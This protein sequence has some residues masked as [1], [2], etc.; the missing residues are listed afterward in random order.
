MADGATIDFK[1]CNLLFG[2]YLLNRG[3][4]KGDWLSVVRDSEAFTKLMGLDG[5]GL[6][7]AIGDES[8]TINVTLL[9]SS[10]LNDILS[11][12]H[13][14]DKAA[15][16]GLLLPLTF[17]EANGR[18]AYAAAGARIA[19]VADGVWSDGGTVRTWTLITTRLYAFVGGVGT[20]P[21]NPNP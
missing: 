13:I 4:A 7:V 16:G 19:K 1:R 3:R 10:D 12:L 18:T 6:Y 15:P 5:E 8:A 9:Q 17:V 20:T 11:A 14:A 2:P 21:T